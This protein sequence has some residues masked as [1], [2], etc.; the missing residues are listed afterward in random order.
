ML[1]LPATREGK[2]SSGWSMARVTE[3]RKGRREHD[4]V[5]AILK[6]AN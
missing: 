4:H 6:C 1:K 2:S 5:F 3:R